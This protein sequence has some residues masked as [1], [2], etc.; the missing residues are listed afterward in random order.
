MSLIHN[1]SEYDI[2]AGLDYYDHPVPAAEEDGI[3][4]NLGMLTKVKVS[5]QEV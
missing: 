2:R 1:S 4:L 3:D 5:V